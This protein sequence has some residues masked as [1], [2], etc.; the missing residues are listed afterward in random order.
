MQCT[1]I[2]Y[3]NIFALFLHLMSYCII[4]RFV[5]FISD[6]TLHTDSDVVFMVGVGGQPSTEFIYKTSK[7]LRNILKQLTDYNVNVSIGM[8]TFSSTVQLTFP[9]TKFSNINTFQSMVHIQGKNSKSNITAAL[10][11]LRTNIGYPQQTR[12]QIAILIL[13]QSITDLPKV[14]KEVGRFIQE[15]HVTLALIVCNADVD[16]SDEEFGALFTTGISPMYTVIMEDVDTDRLQSLV[17]LTKY[18]TCEDD[19]F[20]KRL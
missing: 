7:V 12:R 18:Y 1:Y 5:S 20:T 2:S 19:I 3:G 13:Q 16:A 10:E 17:S 15:T 11:F 8:A 6:C 4:L 14:K 9:V